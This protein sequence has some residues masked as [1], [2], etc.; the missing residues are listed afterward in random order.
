MNEAG[1]NENLNS[2]KLD[3]FNS[4]TSKKGA[5]KVNIPI[6]RPSGPV[7]HFSGNMSLPGGALDR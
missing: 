6:M 1:Q 2:K 4:D 5:F 7:P 3:S